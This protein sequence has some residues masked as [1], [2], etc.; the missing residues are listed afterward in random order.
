MER[1]LQH[2]NR[3]R[4]SNLPAAIYQMMAAAAVWFIVSSWLFFADDGYV[5]YLLVVVSGFIL[6]CVALPTAAWLANRDRKRDRKPPLADWARGE[7]DTFS[8]PIE[9]GSA[10]IQIM[11]PLA[12][13]SLGATAIGLALAAS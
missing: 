10:L 11:A 4:W 5:S 2:H 9:S 12:A 6:F 8:G 7:F 13:V 1:Q 3:P